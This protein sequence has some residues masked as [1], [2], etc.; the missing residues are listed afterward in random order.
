MPS[1]SESH[2]RH[3][4]NKFAERS[5]FLLDAV[6]HRHST[7]PMLKPAIQWLIVKHLL[8]SFDESAHGRS[9]DQACS[10]THLR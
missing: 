2:S 3:P 5:A 6:S 1:L 9:Y 10:R 7:A 8:D 4:I